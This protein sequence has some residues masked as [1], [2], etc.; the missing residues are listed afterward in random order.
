MPVSKRLCHTT[1]RLTRLKLLSV[2][3]SDPD[4]GVTWEQAQ[5]YF[6]LAVWSERR[7]SDPH[8]CLRRHAVI[9]LQQAREEYRAQD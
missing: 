5:E 1:F 3:A 2:K 4:I 9:I 7:F 8:G 6:R